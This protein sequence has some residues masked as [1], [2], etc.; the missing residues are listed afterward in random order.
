MLRQY[1][2]INGNKTEKTSFEAHPQPEKWQPLFLA[3]SFFHAVVR[4]RRRFGPLGWTKLYDFNDSDFRISMRQLYIMVEEFDEVPFVALQY[5]TGDCN[6]GGRV[7]DDRDR[8]ALAAILKDF[9]TEN[10]YLQDEYY[11]A[12]D[13]QK[14]YRIFRAEGIKDYLE[15]VK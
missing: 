2:M 15:Y 8:I 6:Y 10:T 4:E 3:L 5:L 9:Y 7:T 13:S 12:G 1:A 11:F 14:R